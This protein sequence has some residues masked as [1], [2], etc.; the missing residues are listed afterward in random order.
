MITTAVSYN[1]YIWSGD[2]SI[3]VIVEF[4]STLLR[5]LFASLNYGDFKRKM[6]DL[7]GSEVHDIIAEIGCLDFRII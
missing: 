3:K 7:D 6:A 4:D 1:K 2:V 5:N